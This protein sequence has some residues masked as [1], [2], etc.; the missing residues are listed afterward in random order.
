[1][2]RRIIRH[3]LTGAFAIWATGAAVADTAGTCDDFPG[4]SGEKSCSRLASD[5]SNAELNVVFEEIQHRLSKDQETLDALF[6]A[7]ESWESFARAECSF[8]ESGI[9]SGSTRALIFFYCLS[10]LTDART[11]DLRQYLDCQE[12]DLG[13]PVPNGD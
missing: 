7:Q 9:G 13:C 2:K 8:R 10:A 12:G 11:A 1:M 6:Q 4:Q 5:A 3:C